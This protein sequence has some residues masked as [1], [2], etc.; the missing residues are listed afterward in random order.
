M[1]V[2]GGSA[3]MICD[4]CLLSMAGD[5]VVELWLFGLMVARQLVAD[6]PVSRGLMQL[7]FAQ[8]DQ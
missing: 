2:I 1:A 4:D 3:G 7:D 6:A 8:V 5:S